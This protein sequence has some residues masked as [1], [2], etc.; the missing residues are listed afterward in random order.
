MILPYPP[1]LVKQFAGSQETVQVPEGDQGTY[2]TLAKATQVT[3]KSLLDANYPLWVRSRII[4][5]IDPFDD[6]NSWAPQVDPSDTL[7]V[8]E[9]AFDFDV[10]YD[11]Y[12]LDPLVLGS[13][14]ISD[15]VQGP[16]FTLFKAGCGDC[17]AHAIVL[18]SFSISLGHGAKF[19]VLRGTDPTDPTRFSH[20]YAMLG[21]PS[22]GWV[23][24]DTTDPQ[25]SFNS[26]RDDVA[27]F[28][29]HDLVVAPIS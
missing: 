3:S 17:L 10:L 22:T 20:V 2:V 29:P 5:G 25:G 27:S 15:Y 16:H 26:E 13:S 21:S 7:S 24:C 19:R 11:G 9:Q 8:F 23:A 12:Q 18:C 14:S 28:D 6:S 1:A 4:A